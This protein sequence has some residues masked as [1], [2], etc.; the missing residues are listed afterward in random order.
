MQ[1]GEKFRD[2]W[3]FR[4]KVLVSSSDHHDF[5]FGRGNS[6]GVQTG[7]Q[8]YFLDSHPDGGT[9]GAKMGY[10]LRLQFSAFGDCGDGELN[11]LKSRCTRCTTSRSDSLSLIF[12][13]SSKEKSTET[14]KGQLTCAGRVVRQRQ[15]TLNEVH[16]PI[17]SLHGTT[18]EL[19]GFAENARLTFSA[20]QLRSLMK[21]QVREGEGSLDFS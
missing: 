17:L 8:E 1:A 9:A 3:Q 5:D 12:F 6:S 4:L 16:G 15:A 10:E 18:I 2:L 7:V 21:K 11:R 20:N 19:H 14:P 13:I